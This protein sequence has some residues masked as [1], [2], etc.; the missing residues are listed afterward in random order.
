MEP[1]SSITK[2]QSDGSILATF[3]TSTG[4]MIDE[5]VLKRLVLEEATSAE[6][7]KNDLEE[8]D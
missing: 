3:R 5:K 4:W 2:V 7:P 6:G 8:M 1:P